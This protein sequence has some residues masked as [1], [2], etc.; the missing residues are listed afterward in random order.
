MLWQLTTS[1]RSSDAHMATGNRPQQTLRLSCG[2]KTRLFG[3]MGF[4]RTS[5]DDTCMR[6]RRALSQAAIATPGHRQHRSWHPHA[7]NRCYLG[8][9]TR[10][11]A[12]HEFEDPQN[13][14]QAH[15]DRK[16]ASHHKR[17]VARHEVDGN[18]RPTPG[19][20][21]PDPKTCS[22]LRPFLLNTRH[23][24]E[25]L[26]WPNASLSCNTESPGPILPMPGPIPGRPNPGCTEGAW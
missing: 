8:Q 21:L 13:K 2:D 3:A 22:A 23:P 7:A 6:R 11:G 4:F 24:S 14:S 12:L 20:S 18:R 10:R 15:G 26:R 9:C 17:E 5:G 25:L 16:Y 19:H 1:L